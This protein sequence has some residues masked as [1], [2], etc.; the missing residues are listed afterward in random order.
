[1]VDHSL[2]ATV[3][4]WL[5]HHGA[6]ARFDLE[7]AL[8]HILD[9]SRAYVLTHPDRALTRPELDQLEHWSEQLY[10][11]VPVAYL[12]GN[13]EFWGL[14]LTV[15]HRVLVPRPDTE[16]L[17][18]Q[19]LACVDQR[20]RS[21]AT[22]A[23]LTLLDLG[24]GSGAIALALA[25]ER[26][27]AEVHACDRSLDSLA[28]ARENSRSLKLPVTFHH[29]DWFENISQRYDLIVS[30]PPY[31]APADPHLSLLGAEPAHALVANDNGLAD[32][33]TICEGAG[34]FLQ[35]HGWLLLEHGYNQAAAVRSLLSD[36]GFIDVQSR[37][38]LG[39]NE[40]VTWGQK[41][42][43]QALSAHE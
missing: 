36:N 33:R 39:G 8:C 7:L 10:K 35:S 11:H 31:I 18:E 14:S 9:C 15:D 13:Q 43:D 21:P 4:S 19:A 27:E 41:P 26:P 3:A 2:N 32:L 17:V 28:V 16:T 5:R 1:M 38:D 30:N 37:R 25:S 34:A 22:G 23:A 20:D 29:S 12:C 40:R 6:L 24:T 42:W